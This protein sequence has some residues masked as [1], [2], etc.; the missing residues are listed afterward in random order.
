MI[1]MRY[2]N[3][4]QTDERTQKNTLDERGFRWSQKSFADAN[5][6]KIVRILYNNP[7]PARASLSGLAVGQRTPERSWA[8]TARKTAGKVPGRQRHCHHT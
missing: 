8:R 3:A 6:H 1:K 5:G 4:L 7:T 2:E